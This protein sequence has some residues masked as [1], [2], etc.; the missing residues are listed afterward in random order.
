MCLGIQD[1][2]ENY[3][4]VFVEQDFVGNKRQ[5][6]FWL[7][8]KMGWEES[9]IRFLELIVLWFLVCGIDF[10][11]QVFS[12]FEV[13]KF[14]YYFFYFFVRILIEFQVLFIFSCDGCQQLFGLVELIVWG[15]EWRGRGEERK[16]YFL[17]IMFL[18]QFVIFCLFL[19][20]LLVF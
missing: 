19:L 7:W 14:V 1:I 2:F 12:L 6:G 16:S 5:G 9:F 18:E 17:V 10:V 8:Y 11:F 13:M 15:W 4:F 20:F 3:W